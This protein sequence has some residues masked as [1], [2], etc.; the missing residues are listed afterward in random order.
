MS[1]A[2]ALILVLLSAQT[3]SAPPPAGAHKSPWVVRV[4]SAEWVEPGTEGEPHADPREWLLKVTVKF[5][6]KGPEGEV[7]APVLKV[8][9]GAGKKHIMLARLKMAGCHNLMFWLLSPA[10]V[11]GEL[12]PTEASKTIAECKDAVSWYFSFSTERLP[13]PPFALVFADAK[14]IPLSLR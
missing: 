1:A 5:E 9:D 6:Y 13:K 2:I 4:V 8:T 11:V 3:A 7:S 10:S 14:P 12:Q